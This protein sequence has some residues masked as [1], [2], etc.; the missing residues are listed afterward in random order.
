MY[1]HNQAAHALLHTYMYY[2]WI[3]VY[4]LGNVGQQ[5]LVRIHL[6]S[7]IIIAAAFKMAVNNFFY[8]SL[9]I[10]CSVLHLEINSQSLSDCPGTQ[11]IG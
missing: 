4:K 9:L 10:S 11:A 1:V 5:P 6:A 8:I 2:A 3:L 7:Q